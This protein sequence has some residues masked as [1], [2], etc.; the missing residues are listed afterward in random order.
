MKNDV[1]KTKKE[2]RGAG[3]IGMLLRYARP[4]LPAVLLAL[5]CSLIQIAATLAAPVIIGNTVD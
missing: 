2:K 3:A 5:L 1:M 4:Y